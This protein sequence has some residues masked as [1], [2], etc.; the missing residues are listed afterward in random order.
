MQTIKLREIIEAKGL[1]FEHVG[2]K[3]FPKAR[4]PYMAIKRVMDGKAVLD[5]D[6]ISILSQL[7]D[8]PVGYLFSGGE[9][10]AS[11]KGSIITFTSGEYIAELNTQTWQTKIYEKGALFHDVLIHPEGVA[12]S[13]YLKQINEIIINKAK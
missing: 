6:Q 4:F 7:T 12:L 8:I 5:A 1:T 3:L 13:S 11:L 10:G 9:W 2:Q